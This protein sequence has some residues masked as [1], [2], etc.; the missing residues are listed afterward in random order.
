MRSK[1]NFLLPPADLARISDDKVALFWSKVEKSDGCWLWKGKPVRAGY[2]QL[3]VNGAP[4]LAHRI[5]YRIAFGRDPGEMCVCHRCDNRLCVNP[6]HL[7]LGTRA[8]NN[9]DMDAKGRRRSRG[10]SGA[11]HP[12]Y[13]IPFS[14][15]A[16]LRQSF[17]S[18]AFRTVSDAASA[19]GISR[20]HA[21]RLIEMEARRYA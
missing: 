21:R 20:S 12:N 3:K 18:G 14:V 2:G 4:R 11:Q 9:A 15:V 13:R 10:L 1:S 17:W 19:H 16:D 5:S 6:A 7:F 8:D